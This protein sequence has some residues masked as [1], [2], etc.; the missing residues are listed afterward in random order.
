MAGRNHHKDADETNRSLIH[1]WLMKDESGRPTG[2]CGVTRDITEKKETR[3]GCSETQKLLEA[4][5]AAAGILFAF[6]L[7]SNMRIPC[8]MGK[9]ADVDR[10]IIISKTK[11]ASLLKI[12]AQWGPNVVTVVGRTSRRIYQNI[13]PKWEKILFS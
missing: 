8:R 1:I 10:A 5:D 11:M 13:W 4:L 12:Q 2:M 3:A 9:A 6:D 7:K